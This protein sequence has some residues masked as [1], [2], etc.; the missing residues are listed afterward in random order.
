[1]KRCWVFTYNSCYPSGGIG[2][3]RGSFDTVE[4]AQIRMDEFAHYANGSLRS[5]DA[6]RGRK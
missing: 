1:M 3:F 6:E 5:G 4:E 2:D